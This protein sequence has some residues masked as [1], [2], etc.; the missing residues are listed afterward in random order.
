MKLKILHI[1]DLHSRF[2]NLAKISTIIKNLEDDNTIIL[3]AG[4]NADFMRIETEGTNGEVSSAI[5]NKIGFDARVFGNNEGFAGKEKGKVISKTSEFPTVTCNLYHSD[6]EKL[7]YLKDAIVINKNGIR[8]LIIGV[9][10]PY[11]EFYNL[12]EVHAKE[13]IDEIRRVLQNYSKSQYDMVVLLSHLGLREDKEL[14]EKI[15]EIDVIIGGHSHSILD[16]PISINETIIH[17]AGSYGE[18]LGELSVDY[19]TRENRITDYSGK[20]IKSSDYSEDQEVISIIEEYSLKANEYLSKPLFKIEKILTHSL[21]EENDIGNLLADALRDVLGTDIGIINSGVMNKGVETGSISKKELLEI[22][23][24]PL[25]PTYIEIQGKDLLNALEKSLLAEYHN[26]DGKGSGF[27]GKWLGNIQVS[28]NVTVKY[29]EEEQPLSKIE[30]ITINGELLNL[31]R[32]YTV[33]TSDY[34]QRGTGYSELANCK[35]ERYNP[36]YLRDTLEDYL[37]KQEFVSKAFKRRF[38]K[39]G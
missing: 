8:V 39:V 6:G 20:L 9:T 26:A 11:N 18:F 29:R 27:R 37:K 12:F 23:P 36:E 1:N 13:P 14:A 30:N 21:S 32:W 28:S 5:L 19:D 3:D 34:L 24:S 33:G 38:I 35:N 31:K 7:E 15:G 25:N 4:D 2:E 10:A 16:E 17:Q 22:C